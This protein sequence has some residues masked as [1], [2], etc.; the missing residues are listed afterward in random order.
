M[1]SDLL[2]LMLD[3]STNDKGY[4]DRNVDII[5]QKRK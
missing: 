1:Y 2:K 3:K 5:K 4:T